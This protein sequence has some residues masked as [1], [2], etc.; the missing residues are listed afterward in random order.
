[1]AVGSAQGGGED[2]RLLESMGE[3]VKATEGA[4]RLD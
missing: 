4:R 3:L 2:L 1:L